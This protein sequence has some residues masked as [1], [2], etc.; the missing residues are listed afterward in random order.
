MKENIH[1]LEKR[2]TKNAEV[3]EWEKDANEGD[4]N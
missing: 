2:F 1:I 3:L 4:N